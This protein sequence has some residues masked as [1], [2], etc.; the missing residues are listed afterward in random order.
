MSAIAH[1]R[2]VAALAA[3][4]STGNGRQWRCPHHEDRTPS[5]TI[6]DAADR[7]LVRCQAGCDTLDVLKRLGLDWPDLFDEPATGKGWT[8]S[9]LQKVGA[10]TNGDGRV[11]LG[12][13]RYLPGGSPKTLAVKGAQRDLWPDPATVDG[14]VLFVVEGEPDAVTATQLGLPAVAIPGAGT[15]DAAWPARIAEGRE[16][17]VIIPDADD[18][19]RKAA[20]K[21]AA[22]VA[23]HCADV[24]VLDL[25]PDRDDGR[26]LSDYAADAVTDV[27]RAELR[28]CIMG[29]VESIKR[30][31]VD[32]VTGPIEG[33]GQVGHAVEDGLAGPPSPDR[34]RGRIIDVREAL[35]EPD[36]PLPWRCD[37]FAADGYLTVI[38]GRGGEGKSWLTLSLACGVARGANVA[39]I[40]CVQGR[41]LIFDAENGR[42][43]IA[44]RLRAAQVG[45]QLAVQ[46]VD[47]GGLHV[48]RDIG[49]FRD[50]IEREAANLVVFD[51][52]RVLSSGAKENDSDVMEPIMT[53]L[54]QL[55]RETG[56]AIVLVHH[57][58]R[59]EFSDFRGS[60]VILDQTDLLFTLGRVAADPDGRHR[61]KIATVKCRIDEEPAPR[62]VSINADRA[63]ALVTIDVAEPFEGGEQERPRDGLRD[64]VLE[65]LGGIPRS[66]RSVAKAVG[67]REDDSTVKRV[68]ADLAGDGLAEK[69]DGGWVR[70]VPGTVA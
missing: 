18:V 41:A 67:R 69:R 54:K 63:R 70:A 28:R 14:P 48:I 57:R 61:R 66:A 47:A 59:S 40:E 49:W 44:R 8:R 13:V 17:V 11:T 9:T 56:A 42:R 68:L 3:H 12:A 52:L 31:N 6:T 39:G 27:D 24:R 10:T 51:S 30:Y 21:W 22:A 64:E 55:A 43:L 50:V 20:T 15:F 53:A 7:V 2:L 29:A 36:T 1:T 5:L 38:A 32:R 26:D 19:G 35:A 62:W 23:A 60:S 37:G 33:V 25:E 16:R 58:G 4:G 65:V 34:Y 46:P 45:P